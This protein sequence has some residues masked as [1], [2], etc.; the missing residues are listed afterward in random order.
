PDPQAHD[1]LIAGLN[2][3]PYIVNYSGHGSTGIWAS[4]SYFSG[5]DVPLLV[6]GANQSIYT[7]LTCYNGYFV[8]PVDDSLGELLL[9]APN[10]GGVATWA[11]TTETTPDLQLLMGDRFYRQISF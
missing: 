2:A 3:G 4:T 5:N 11:S 1:H 6:N 10:G 7:M 8:R 9:K